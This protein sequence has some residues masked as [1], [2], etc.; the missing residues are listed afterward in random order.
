LPKGEPDRFD[1]LFPSSGHSILGSLLDLFSYRAPV[2]ACFQDNR[3]CFLLALYV[4]PPCLTGD[5]TS[6]VY[7]PHDQA[8]LSGLLIRRFSDGGVFF[9]LR[10]RVH[11]HRQDGLAALRCACHCASFRWPITIGGFAGFIDGQAAVI[12]CSERT[13]ACHCSLTGLKI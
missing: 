5:E 2:A 11:G 1:P 3:A 6:A 13:A 12:R 7:M 4:V 9:K 10:F 8:G